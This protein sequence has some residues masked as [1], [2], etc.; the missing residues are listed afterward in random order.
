MAADADVAT[1]AED[2]DGEDDADDDGVA[3]PP[4]V[5]H[6]DDVDVAVIAAAAP[7]KDDGMATPGTCCPPWPL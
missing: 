6:A 1:A 4:Q 7:T 3:P 2:A 5:P